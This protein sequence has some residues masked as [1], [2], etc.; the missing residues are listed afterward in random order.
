MTTPTPGLPVTPVEGLD[1]A[2]S[3]FEGRWRRGEPAGHR[4]VLPP[5]GPHR[6]RVLVEFVHAELEFRLKAGEPAAG[7]EYFDRYPELHPDPTAAASLATAAD[8]CRAG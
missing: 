6:L 5:A 2:V 1:T 4:R 3:R 8:G 7:A